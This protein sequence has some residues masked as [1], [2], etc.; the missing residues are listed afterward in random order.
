MLLRQM[1][2]PAIM[3]KIQK[4]LL[5]AAFLMSMKDFT[6]VNKACKKAPLHH[7]L[8]WSYQTKKI[9]CNSLYLTK[10]ICIR[11]HLH[12]VDTLLYPAGWQDQST[13]AVRFCE[14]L[15]NQD[16]SARVV[17]FCKLVSNQDQSARVVQFCKLVSNQ[18]QSTRAGRFCPHL[19]QIW[20]C[21]VMVRGRGGWRGG[22]VR[23][24]RGTGPAAPVIIKEKLAVGPSQVSQLWR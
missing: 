5:L 19:G 20:E 6:C 11:C 8:L 12:G 22:G 4:E 13:R 3:L 7:G 2:R 23:G 24:R 21:W 15:S 16:Q 18:D 14:L 1:V 17:R 9:G 10:F